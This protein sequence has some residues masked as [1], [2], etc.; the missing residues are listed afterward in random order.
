MNSFF[1]IFYLFIYLFLAALGPRCYAP[2][3]SSCGEQGL[4]FVVVRG[5]L[6]A[7]AS[8]AAERGL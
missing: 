2:A 8:P 1:K 5:L 7:V 6:T 4:L 3:L